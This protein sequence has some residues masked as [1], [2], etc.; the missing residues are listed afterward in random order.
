MSF[1]SCFNAMILRKIWAD[2]SAKLLKNTW[3]S[4][5]SMHKNYSTL[6]ERELEFYE[7]TLKLASKALDEKEV[8]TGCLLVFEGTVIA[9][10]HG[11]TIRYGFHLILYSF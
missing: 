1:F 6:S 8:P 2:F 10:A 5:C 4:L 3:R 7:R 9:E 11:Q